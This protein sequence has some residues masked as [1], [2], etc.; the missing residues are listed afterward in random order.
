LIFSLERRI[1]FTAQHLGTLSSCIQ[2]ISSLLYPFAW[3]HVYIPVLPSDLIDIVCSPTPYIIGIL[4]TS[5]AALQKLPMEEVLIVD[6]DNNALLESLGDE[7]TI[8][9]RKL[10]KALTG[11]LKDTDRDS[12]DAVVFE[13]FLRLFVET[14]GHYTD[15]ILVQ[16][17]GKNVFQKDYFCR[18]VNSKSIRM[19]LEWFV[20]TQMFEVF[21]T[22]K[23]EN[24][25]PE[26]GYF[27]TRILEYRQEMTESNRFRANVKELGRKMISFMVESGGKLKKAFSGNA[28]NVYV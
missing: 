19:F 2:A 8:V 24:G 18:A 9:P 26:N 13:A 11:A 27:E 7:A 5:R 1:L 10:Q 16:Q 3:Q 17:D 20:E 28:N 14:I 22:E 12:R 4:S 23:L 6:L 21:M 25:I 15:Y